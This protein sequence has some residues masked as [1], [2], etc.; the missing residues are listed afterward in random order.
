MDNMIYI[1][2]IPTDYSITLI[3]IIDLSEPV[4]KYVEFEFPILIC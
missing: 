3:Y 4:E 1:I 2:L